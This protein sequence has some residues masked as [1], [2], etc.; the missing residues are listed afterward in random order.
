MKFSKLTQGFQKGRKVHLYF[1]GKDPEL[2]QKSQRY[3]KGNA[4]PVE[5]A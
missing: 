5:R 1:I 4:V 2:L 3:I